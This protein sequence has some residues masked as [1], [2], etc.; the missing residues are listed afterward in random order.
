MNRLLLCGHFWQDSVLKTGNYGNTHT[1]GKLPKHAFYTMRQH[2][3]QQQQYTANNVNH[4]AITNVLKYIRL[5]D[6]E[7]RKDN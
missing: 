4:L 1:C 6:Y 3:L 5:S 2:R 7:N